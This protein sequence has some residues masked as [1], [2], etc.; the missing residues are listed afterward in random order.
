MRIID[1]IQ[2]LESWAPRSLQE[3]YD[4]SGLIF[5]SGQT[6]CTGVLCTLDATEEVIAEAVQR[7]CN[8]VVAHHPILFGGLKQIDPTHYVGRA[9]IQA[10][11]NDVAIYAIHTNLDNVLNGV[12]QAM[13]DRLQLVNRK[14]LSPKPHQLKKL[15]TFVPLAHIEN[16][17]NAL[18]QAGAGQI[19]RY[20]RCSFRQSGEGSFRG[21][22]GSAPYVGSVGQQH[23]EPEYKLEVIYPYF[24][25]KD[26][27]GALRESHPYEEV[28]FDLVN[29]TNDH[30]DIGSGLIG[31][32][33]EP[34]DAQAFL[35]RLK[36][37]FFSEGLRYT[38]PNNRSIRRVA[39]CGGAGSFLISK[40]LSSGV[41]AFLTADLKYHEFFEADGKMLLVDLGHYESEQFT[42]GLIQRVL[43]E[44]FPNFAVLKTERITNPV[45]YY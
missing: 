15:Y 5:G 13:A 14:I 34:M 45:R 39:L 41:D 6:E 20:D 24:L 43:A 31:D 23:L 2:V 4:N 10:I 17:S 44:K 42:I 32:L 18:F 28:A 19:G 8:L 1:V 25:E 7:G 12:S 40:A 16:V 21:L 30:P 33:P 37:V 26:I 38:V 27:L 11:R 35:A 22:A 9:L 36:E 3:S 29:L